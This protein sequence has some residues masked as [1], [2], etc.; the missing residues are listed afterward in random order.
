[1]KLSI[2]SD[3]NYYNCFHSNVCACSQ[4]LNRKWVLLFSTTLN[5]IYHPDS[6][7]CGKSILQYYSR[8]NGEL[9]DTTNELLYKYNGLR[10]VLQQDLTWNEF[11]NL[12]KEEISHQRPVVLHFNTFYAPWSK[13]YRKEYLSEFISITQINEESITLFDPYHKKDE[14][15]LSKEQLRNSL[16]K[17]INAW[18][19]DLNT[20]I[21]ALNGNVILR[22]IQNYYIQNNNFVNLI[23]Q[24]SDRVLNTFDY[25]IEVLKYEVIEES[26]IIKNLKQLSYYRLVHRDFLNE[27]ISCIDNR[28]NRDNVLHVI[29]R[30]NKSLQAWDKLRAVLIY[31]KIRNDLSSKNEWMYN[32]LNEIADLEKEILLI[33]SR[34]K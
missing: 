30:L 3:Q 31:K 1:M 17:T 11:L 5:F 16:V 21:S 34:F 10:M 9:P 29:D 24:F 4:Y 19:F 22:N 32:K 8:P 14:I 26:P 33:Y 12:I 7:T 23:K 15:S 18:T 2:L 28:N 20:Q 13:L 25:E 6:E 27:I